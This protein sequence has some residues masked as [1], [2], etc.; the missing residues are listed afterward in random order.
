MA[1]RCLPFLHIC[2]RELVL[3][4]VTAPAG[5]I[6]CWLFLACMEVLHTC[7]RY[8]QADQVEAYSANTACLWAYASRKV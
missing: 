7:D 6:S 4:D 5:A 2:T 3:L 1:A 8:N